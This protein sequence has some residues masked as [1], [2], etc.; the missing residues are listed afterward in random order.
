MTPDSVDRVIL[1]M[2]QENAR[3][4]NAEIARTVGIAP[5]GVLERI[6]KLEQRGIIKGYHADIDAAALGQGLTAFV[7]MRTGFN[8]EHTKALEAL[9]SMPVVLEIHE[10]AGDDCLMLKIRVADMKAYSEFLNN[11]IRKTEGIRDTS[12]TMVISTAKNHQFVD[13]PDPD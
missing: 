12:T 8:D 9:V 11:R 7:R 10:T 2:L 1:S 6:R 4:S 3:T 13:I 5:S